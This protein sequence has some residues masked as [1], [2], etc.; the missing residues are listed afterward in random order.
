MT[1]AEKFGATLE[2][3]MYPKEFAQFY[4]AEHERWSKVVKELGITLD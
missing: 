4:A 1:S 3:F 2:C